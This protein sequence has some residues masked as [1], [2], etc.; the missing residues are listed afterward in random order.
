MERVPTE[1]KKQIQQARLA[2]GM[3]QGQLAQV[4]SLQ[5]VLEWVLVT[6]AETLPPSA[7]VQ[8]AMWHPHFD[9]PLRTC[10]II[11][12]HERCHMANDAL[13]LTMPFFAGLQREAS[14][15]PRIRVW[16]SHPESPSVEQN[17]TRLGSAT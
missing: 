16:Q 10:G 7:Q 3:T 2:K 1:L 13:I 17:V 9:Q 8:K 15:Y 14:H 6:Q 5:G 4:R 12:S 11:R